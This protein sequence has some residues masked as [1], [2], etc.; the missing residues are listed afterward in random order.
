MVR[1]VAAA[2][3]VL[4]TL[5][6]LLV[7]VAAAEAGPGSRIAG[8]VWADTNRDGVRQPGEPP[9]SGV[10]VELLTS[11]GGAVVAS[12]TTSAGGAY[13]FPNLADGGYIVR[14]VA[15]GPFTFPTSASGDDDF[16]REGTPL[17]GQPERG[18]SAQ[19]TILGAT[20]I[21]GL[22]AGLLP[23]ADLVVAKLALPAA[24]DGFAQTGTPPFDATEGPGQD[25][26]TA[27]CI[28]R[29]DDTVRQQYAVSLTGLPTGASVPNVVLELRVSSPDG[30]S[31]SLAGP[32]PN[33]IP[34]GCL[35]AANGANPA[36]GRTLNPDGSITVTCNIGPMSSN[37]AALELTYR[38]S[39]AS[40]VPSHASIAA[41]AYAGQ[42]DA[43]ESATESGPAVELTARPA[44][45]LQK[46]L[47]QGPRQVTR[48]IDGVT[49][50]GL[51]Q[52]YIFGMNQTGGVRGDG[53]LAWPV[54]FTDV[55]AGFP[56]ARIVSCPRVSPGNGFPAAYGENWWGLTCPL[57]EPQGNDGWSLRIAPL[58]GYEQAALAQPTGL[59]AMDVFIPDVD[60]FRA[61]N[62]AWQPGDPRPT[63]TVNWQNQAIDTG[64][65]AMNGGQLNNGTGYE[66][67]WNGT[68]ASGNNVTSQSASFTDP[69]WDLWKAL[70][71]G[72]N[73]TTHVIDG[74]SVQGYDFLYT[75]SV[76]ETNGATLAHFVDNV[77]FKDL[78]AS[79]PEARLE[80]CL[81]MGSGTWANTGTPTCQLGTQPAGGWNMSLTV[82]QKGRDLRLAQFQARIFLP[83]LTGANPCLADPNATFRVRNEAVESGGWTVD[84]VP[85]NGGTGFEPGWDGSVASGNNVVQGDYRVRP[86]S[87]CPAAGTLTGNKTWE[88]GPTLTWPGRNMSTLVTLNASNDQINQ[89]DVT[90]CDV[91][92]VSVLKLADVDYYGPGAV[93]R[94]TTSGTINAA[95]Y[96]VEFAIGPNSTRTQAPVDLTPIQNAAATCRE[97]TG[98]WET[99]PRAFGDDWQNQV[100]MIRVRPLQAG[101]VETGPFG[102]TLA[103]RL[104]TRG[105]YNGGPNAGTV[106]PSGIYVNNVGGWTSRDNAANWSTVTRGVPFQGMRLAIAKTVPQAQYLPGDAFR[107]NVGLRIESAFSGAVMQ[108]VRIVDTLPPG[109]D[110]D[111]VCTKNQLPAGVSLTYDP[112]AKKL[113]FLF[114]DVTLGGQTQDIVGYG[115]P[116][117]QICVTVPTL[118]Q[119]G[120]LDR[121]TVQGFADNSGNS[122]TATSQVQ[123]AGVGQLGIEKSVDKPYVTSGETYTWSLEW[124]N[125]STITAFQAPDVIDV[126]P[127][128]GD[129]DPGSGSARSQYA[130][131]YVGTSRLTGQ[132]AAPTYIRGATGSVPGTWY[133]SSDDPSTL[134]HD[135]RDPSNADPGG[136]DDRWQTAA[137][138]AGGR[139]WDAVTA[140]R[141]VSSSPLTQQTGVRARIPQ[142][143]TSTRLDNLYVNRAMITSATVPDQPLLSN[144]PYVLMPG[145]TLGDLVWSDVNGNGV[146]DGPDRGVPGVTVQ[147]RDG[148]GAVVATRVT[149]EDGR[150]SVEALP[151][152]TYTAHIPASMFDAG[153]PLADH[154]VR[155][156]KS[157]ANPDINEENDNNNTRTND[158]RFSGLTSTPVTLSYVY[159]GGRLVGGNGPP[160]DDVAGLSPQ[161]IPDSFTNFTLDLALMPAPGISVEKSTNGAD[162][163]TAPGPSIAVGQP[164]RWSYVVLNTGEE[165]LAD[166]TVT[167]DLVP[168]ADIDCAGTGGNVV[169]GPLPP[170]GTFTCLA[171]GAATPGQYENLATVTGEDPGQESVS[172][173]DASHYFGALA[174]VDIEKSTNGLDADAA[175]GPTVTVGGAVR[176]TY[177]VTNRGTVPLTDVAVTDDRVDAAAID[178]DGTG[179][180]VVTGPLAPDASF[181]CVATGTAAAGQY[182]NTGTVTATAPPTTDVDGVITPTP[183]VTDSDASHYL[184]VAPAV[185][186]EKSTNGQDADSA[187]GPL[188]AVGEGVRWTYTVTNRGDVPLT[189]VTVTDDRVPASAIDCATTRTNVVPG[190]LEPGDT[191]T[192]AAEGTAQ[193]GQY[194]NTGT[195]TAFGPETV[196]AD[197]APGPRTVTA[198]DPS[199]YFGS[200]P[201][202]RIEKSV[203]GDDADQPPGL[204]VLSG[205]P[206]AWTYDVTNVGNVPL[207]D[208]EVTDDQLDPSDIAC[209]DGSN[210]VPGPLPPDA[211]VTCRADGT[212]I[213]GPY[214]NLGEAAAFGP[215]T[216]DEEGEPVPPVRVADTDPANYLGVLPSP[217]EPGHGQG[218]GGP[219]AGPGPAASDDLA[220][221]GGLDQ[222]AVLL[223][224]VLLLLL[225]A[226]IIVV[227]RRRRRAT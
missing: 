127:W 200:A 112:I 87:G 103:A 218:G 216:I 158:R 137:E 172:D 142:V 88:F 211:A 60:W 15:P 157:S 102:M 177:V 215:V 76:G 128:N 141:F 120:D 67:G 165:P 170:G 156:V 2:L 71:A 116:P 107:W 5:C 205:E 155:T 40:A 184:G 10:A 6:A 4:G 168:A 38:M 207:S 133:Y 136:P 181:A 70:S 43:G 153:E 124:G 173:T 202:I 50:Q 227:A 178:C 69:K 95:N 12:T 30:A 185:G 226:R 183:P 24:C 191:V 188:V 151:P 49:V 160:D 36:S 214:E 64:G 98:R 81:A 121:N 129:G 145:F 1:R 169:A 130:S 96:V 154:V 146:F 212:A 62:P 100:N 110:Y 122:P 203:N 147:V 167:D 119:P 45:D 89:A 34:A 143:A 28:L 164:V 14:V 163:D 47:Y 16:V 194:A 138:V 78:L 22:D 63:G 162:A 90:L 221:T 75:F 114:G 182:E 58:A 27:N 26:G 204:P 23:I 91:F 113:T 72:P 97:N 139:G 3:A 131:A 134:V 161:V 20:Q 198:A 39:V 108:N 159:S 118:A 106:I 210:L 180:D 93:T 189:D 73:Y 149:D 55:L 105:V 175:P 190:P 206:V 86:S 192:C 51:E 132:L 220:A 19:Q 31:L 193:A 125:T 82:N 117:L 223:A 140:V 176:W 68:T 174:R 57:N 179:S 48:T 171:T 61:L 201:A 123:I 33:G 29:T 222:T 42:G 84:G 104:D 199:H 85:I 13:S 208:L 152:G 32:G 187:P 219:A 59:V 44:W 209:A 41:R 109:V 135:P 37:V 74:A 79:H 197:G 101:R 52:W 217:G 94:L 21:T 225:G 144:E 115:K 7:P 25:T 99:D 46:S 195:V 80:Q 166:V 77:T 53:S 148:A 150:W 11:P 92:D 196:D 35:T 56:D 126:L 83:N 18:V 213:E 65:W 54:S 8:V 17:P 9:K 224:A 111:P 66:P 186:I